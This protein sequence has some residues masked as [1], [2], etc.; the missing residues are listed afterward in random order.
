MSGQSSYINA[1]GP[2]NPVENSR[3]QQSQISCTE[4][5]ARFLMTSDGTKDCLALLVPRTFV[6]R[7]ADLF[8]DSSSINAMQSQLNQVKMDAR[9]TELS[10]RMAKQSIDIIENGDEVI[11]LQRHLEHQEFRLPEICKRRDALE[12]ATRNMRHEVEISRAHTEW[13]LETAMEAGS[14]LKPRQS[15][16]PVEYD[17]DNVSRRSAL[18]AAVS[19]GPANPMVDPA[20]LRRREANE[21]FRERLH[22]LEE[23]QRLFHDKEREYEERLVDWK[24]GEFDICRSEFDRRMLVY[25]QQ[26]TG[27]LIDREASFELAKERAEEL[28]VNSDA[29][30]SSPH[31]HRREGR[32]SPEEIAWRVSSIDRGFIDAWRAD[33]TTSGC[34]EDLQVMHA[35]HVDAGLVQISD[36][37][38]AVDDGEYTNMI[39]R[40][41]KARGVYEGANRPRTNDLWTRDIGA[42]DR[43]FSS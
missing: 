25:N 28:S 37:T 43:R 10:I 2:L 36:S 29:S 35:E 3:D 41:Q 1:Q 42:I 23:A 9:D 33:I 39:N 21:E 34:Q 16:I 18:S 22:E 24:H 30:Q 26:I 4:G 11:N 17:C 7:L 14:L 8:N 27:V 12:E 13:V 32:M 5:P 6:K 40:W 20:E 38:S 15:F 19:I 31:S